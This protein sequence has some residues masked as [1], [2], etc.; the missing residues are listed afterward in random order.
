MKKE[1]FILKCKNCG[2]L[3]H[4]NVDGYAVGD[5]LLEGVMFY[6]RPGK[7]PGTWKAEVHATDKEYFDDLNTKKWLKAIE[8]DVADSDT[9]ECCKCGTDIDGPAPKRV[10]RPI[11]VPMRNI[12]DILGAALGAS[13]V[14][15]AKLKADLDKAQNASAAELLKDLEDGKENE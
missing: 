3:E 14:P 15:P 6:V 8:D 7:K 5:R 2:P 9:L 13:P 10:A 12:K 11:Q 4:V 1:V